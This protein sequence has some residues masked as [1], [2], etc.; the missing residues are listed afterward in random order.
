MSK[1]VGHIPVLLEEITETIVVKNDS[2]VVDGTVG[3]GGHSQSLAKPLSKEG[4]F[5]GYDLDANA[6]EEAQQTLTHIQA[7]KHFLEENVVS[8]KQTL[9]PLLGTRKVDVFFLDLGW[10]SHQLTSGRGFSFLKDEPLILSYATDAKKREYDAMDILNLWSFE[11]IR[12]VF[13]YY[14]EE[15]RAAQY[16]RDIVRRRSQKSITTTQDLASIICERTQNRGKIHPAT[17]VFQ[18]LRIAVN[19]ELE[20]LEKVLEYLPSFLNTNAMVG[21]IS[22]HSLEDRIVKRCFK[23]WA[24]NDFGE[25]VTKKPLRPTYQERKR[26]P[27]SRSA[28]CRIFK[29]Y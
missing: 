26:N 20:V 28:K 15:K 10:G 29:W 3:L 16:A 11:A 7:E 1:E 24:R 14:G 27:R 25:I 2:V 23:D 12:D 21:I 4:L 18:A 17:K 13:L 8:I 9:P 5:I 6:L 22:F 19:D